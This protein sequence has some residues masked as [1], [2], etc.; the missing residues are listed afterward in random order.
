MKLQQFKNNDNMTI[1]VSLVV[2]GYNNKT[3]NVTP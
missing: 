2:I 3:A 1:H